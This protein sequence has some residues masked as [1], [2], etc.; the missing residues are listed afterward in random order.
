MKTEGNNTLEGTVERIVFFNEENSYTVARLNSGEHTQLVTVVGCLAG[1]RE[2]EYV[3]ASGCWEDNP[4]FGPQFRIDRCEI[5]P[6]SSIQGIEKYLSSGLIKGIGPVM[7]ERIVKKF[8]ADTLQVISDQPKRLRQ[9]RGIG[10]KTLEK[11]IASW[12]QHKDLRETM[13]FL[14]ANGISPAYATR[15]IKQYGGMAARVVREDPYRLV[16]DVHGIGFKQADSIA[17]RMGI[18]HDSP[19]RAAACAL[20]VLGEMAAEGHVFCPMGNLIER[21]EKM[22][23]VPIPLIEQGI[24]TLVSEKKVVV[25]EANGQM[26]VY[27]APLHIAEAG[28]AHLLKTIR[29]SVKVMPRI[30]T[31]KAIAW[32]EDRHHLKLNPGQ[33]QAIR[34]AFESKVLIITGGPGTGKTTIIRALVEM[35]RAKGQ[36]VQLAAPTG[37]AAKRMEEVAG[38]PAATIH[39]LLEFSPGKMNFLRDRDNPLECDVLIIDETSMLDIALLYHLLKATPDGTVLILVGDADQLP[40]VG[41]GNVLRDMLQSGF[42]N[43]VEL[44]EIFRQ[45]EGSLIVTN[46]H[47]INNGDTP[48]LASGESAKKSDFHFIERATPEEVAATIETVVTARIP[49]AFGMDPLFDIQVLSPMHKGVAGVSDLNMRLQQL[50]NPSG[51]PIQHGM[52]TFRVR[53]KVMQI[54]NNYE[55]DVFNG[56]L[57]IVFSIDRDTQQVAV[58][59]DARTVIYEFSELDELELAYAIS[60]HKS[61]GSEYRAVVVPVIMQHYILLQRNLIYTAVT[62]GKE[63]VVLVGTQQALSL[64]VRNAKIQNRNTRLAKRLQDNVMPGAYL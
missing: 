1:V 56:D 49:D 29:D 8:G 28:S 22:L 41:P 38:I 58:D 64:A 42:A 63:L 23:E 5:V 44:T 7:A 17:Q 61:Q 24:G 54:R 50:L 43:A 26:I 3:R 13:I 55:K 32:F 11:I 37:R 15:I 40:S 60:V 39:R 25:E 57:G 30:D 2:G 52:R 18:P 21:C 16:Y 20:H 51:N 14:Q 34:K 62:R 33:R 6:P 10:R 27:L 12:E 45:A 46:A 35:F 53:D 47:R 19:A 48:I 36:R 59:Y 4:K 9:V 31:D